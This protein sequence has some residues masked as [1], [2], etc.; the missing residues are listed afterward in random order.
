M[1]TAIQH[2]QQSTSIATFVRRQRRAQ[3]ITQ[4]QLA[5]FAGVSYSLINRIENGDQN[6]RLQSVD[7]VLKVFGH[8]TGPQKSNFADDELG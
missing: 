3:G 6:L 5:D 4:R 2:R 7:K 8:R 1:A